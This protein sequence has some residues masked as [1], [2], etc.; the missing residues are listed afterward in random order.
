MIP[1]S[2]ESYVVEHLWEIFCKN[3]G[4]SD[5]VKGDLM[6]KEYLYG[7]N[8]MLDQS[9]NG[10]I[11]D[12]YDEE[13]DFEIERVSLLKK[14]NSYGPGNTLLSQLI[15]DNRSRKSRTSFHT[16]PESQ[17]NMSVHSDSKGNGNGARLSAASE[18]TSKIAKATIIL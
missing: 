2:A 1:N 7:A 13:K 18:H 14:S 12:F 6:Q 10:I 11:N 4:N 16:G 5:C 8:T 17:S 15:L 9:I 3:G